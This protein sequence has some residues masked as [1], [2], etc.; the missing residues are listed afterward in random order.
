MSK[1]LPPPPTPPPSGAKDG[2][3]AKNAAALGTAPSFA[4]L[5]RP[6]TEQ[7]RSLAINANIEMHALQDSDSDE[8]L[9]AAVNDISI[10]IDDSSTKEGERRSRSRS[11]ELAKKIWSARQRNV[12]QI[13]GVLCPDAS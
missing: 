2:N 10:E 3:V 6:S 4:N 12:A 13:E 5:Y 11:R 7:R 1:P 8:E 9:V